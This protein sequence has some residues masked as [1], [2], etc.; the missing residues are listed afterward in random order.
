M[1]LQLAIVATGGWKEKNVSE[2][3]LW[4]GFVYQ[5]TNSNWSL[6]SEDVM[7]RTG[8]WARD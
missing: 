4:E 3:V 5:D 8:H 6:I 7:Q 2:V 1:L